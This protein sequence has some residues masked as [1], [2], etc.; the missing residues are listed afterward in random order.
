MKA[1]C[2]LGCFLSVFGALLT[3]WSG[4]PE[5]QADPP[6][7]IGVTAPWLSAEIRVSVADELGNMYPTAAYNSNREEFLV[8]W[9]R[10]RSDNHSEIVGRRVSGSGALLGDEF[11]IASGFFNEHRASPALAY[12]AFQD[13]YAV[14]YLCANYVEELGPSR[15]NQVCG[16]TVSGD[17]LTLGGE[18]TIY[19]WFNRSFWEPRVAW[20]SQRNRYLAVWYACDTATAQPTDVASFPLESDL[21]KVVGVDVAFLVSTGKEPLLP[22]L[23]YNAS[24]DE[25]FIVW[26]ETWPTSDDTDIRGS[27]LDGLQ[28]MRVSGTGV[29]L[30]GFTTALETYPAVTTNGQSR[31]LVVWGSYSPGN[32]DVR[33][34]ELVA[35]GTPVSGYRDIA[36]T[37]L[38]EIFPRVAARPGPTR[39]YLVAFMR[40]SDGRGRIAASYWGDG[41]SGGEI[42]V[43][44][45]LPL[46]RGQPVVTVGNSGFLFVY[47]GKVSGSPEPSR[48]YT[49]YFWPNAH[50]TYLPLVL[51]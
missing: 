45:A 32:W 3:A 47:Q 5:A 49:R 19:A 13:E 14:V 15:E 44:S 41:I 4:P 9:Q 30:I 27:R 18:R 17:G 10:Q 51:R 24:M 37:G 31:Y 26:Q 35:D 43:A 7:R 46:D 2:F 16:R 25:Y 33:G 1:K 6:P 36:V 21:S 29:L 40:F 50:L 42:D 34:K 48:I 39:E 8:V 28:G 12:N 20:N 38:A 11:I 22:D 23:V